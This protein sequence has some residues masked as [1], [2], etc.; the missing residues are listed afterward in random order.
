MRVVICVAKY[1]AR[2]LTSKLQA[3]PRNVF[4]GRTHDG[5]AG[6]GRAREGDLVDVG[7]GDQR[8]ARPGAE[9]RK[10]VGDARGEARVQGCPSDPERRQWGQFSG[11]EHDRAACRKRGC[12][13]SD[14]VHQR[15]V[16]GNNDCD[17]P[18]RHTSC[19]GRA[20]N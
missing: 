4:R 14:R 17:N 18:D 11:F 19:V 13:L 9:A 16:P 15:E 7:M 6:P 2:R 5:P 3:D 8:C 20:R 10:D 1:E 12:D